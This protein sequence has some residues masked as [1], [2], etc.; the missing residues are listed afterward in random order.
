M[1]PY[2]LGFRGFTRHSSKHVSENRGTGAL[3]YPHQDAI[4]RTKVA[5][6]VL[7][8]LATFASLA[9]AASLRQALGPQT[10]ASTS[11]Q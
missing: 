8:V 10:S 9:D 3:I 7:I 11:R 4:L 2:L 1:L 6:R 5:P